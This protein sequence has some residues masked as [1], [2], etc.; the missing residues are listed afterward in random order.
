MDVPCAN[1]AAKV[2]IERDD[3][4]LKC[5]FCESTLYLDRAK[6]FKAFRLPPVVPRSRVADL[7]H[8]HLELLELPRLSVRSCEGLLMPFWGVRGLRVQETI[9]AFSPVPAGF[10]GFRLP[11]AG[12]VPEGEPGP[13]GFERAA[14][15]EGSSAAWEGR[16]DVSGFGL[17]AVPF[18][19]VGYG[20][21]EGTY[22][23]WVDAVEGVVR[24]ESSPPPLT[25]R[26]SKRFWRVMG[27]TFIGLTAEALLIPGGLAAASAVA[28][29]AAAA[30]PVLV[31]LFREGAE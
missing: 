26:I 14:C 7:V 30:Y 13:P 1:C 16:G 8:Q 11:A 18:F 15:S 17:Y 24:L 28:L 2:P 23:A 20:E 4:F 10:A 22:T 12:A 29:T 27:Y 5:P 19:K 6:T 31:G 25:D 9:P 3:P 21:A